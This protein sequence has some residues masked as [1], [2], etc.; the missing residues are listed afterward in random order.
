MAARCGRKAGG[1]CKYGP[2]SGVD[3]Y[4]YGG[5]LRAEGG[6]EVQI[7]TVRWCGYVRIWRR[8][9]G[10][11]RAGSA[12]MDRTLVWIRTNMAARCGRKAGGKCKYGPYAGVDTYEYGG[13]LR[14][15]GGREVQIW[16]VRWCGYVRIWRRAAGGRRAGS[17][18]MD[19]T[20]VWIRTNM[21][22]RCG[23]KAGGK[24]KYGP[25]AGV[26]TYEYG[27]AL[28]AEGGREVQIWTVRW[29]GYVR[30]WRRAAG[31]RRAGSAN[32]DR[33][34][35]WIRTNMAAR[36]GRKAGGKCKYG[37]YAGV[38]TYEYGGA[39]RAE[40]GA[41]RAREAGGQ[42]ARPLRR[43]QQRLAPA[44]VDVLHRAAHHVRRVSVDR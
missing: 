23:R 15:E 11:R 17:A 24:C 13:A 40:G 41:G 3:T 2:Y 14:A 29:C 43:L 22:A 20:L 34:L 21:A 37:P 7:W 42:G 31:G 35:V 5:A 26:D 6:R 9:A 36:C 28:R 1:K 33:T 30:I 18:N 25:Y 8:A 4:E 27:G 10:G 19:R 32:M 38:D 12:N 16:T 44:R 39:L